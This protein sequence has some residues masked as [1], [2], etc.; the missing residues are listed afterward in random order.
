MI[1]KAWVTTDGKRFESEFEANRHQERIALKALLLEAPKGELSPKD[2]E[3]T[4]NEFD[5]RFAEW[6][7]SEPTRTAIL[8]ILRYD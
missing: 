6:M 8:D 7:L 2:E 5:E 1:T 3:A 4:N